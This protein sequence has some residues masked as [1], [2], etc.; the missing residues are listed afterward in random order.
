MEFL[1]LFGKASEKKLEIQ[2]Q[3]VASKA[4][5]SAVNDFTSSYASTIPKLYEV[6]SIINNCEDG[7]S[8]FILEQK[9]DGSNNAY[10]LDYELAKLNDPSSYAKKDES[11]ELF[12]EVLKHYNL[13]STHST[14]HTV[15]RDS[16]V[17]RTC[18]FCS[19]SKSEGASFKKKAHTVPRALGNKYHKSWN[20]CDECNGFF[21][22]N[23]EPDLL[24]FL[25]V[26]RS[27]TGIKGRGKANGYSSTEYEK[28][29]IWHDG[30]N[31]KFAS[32]EVKENEDGSLSI[33]LGKGGSFVP[34]NVYRAITKIALGVIPESEL[35]FLQKTIEWVRH[36][37]SDKEVELPPVASAIVPFNNISSA[38]LMLYVRKANCE[39][40]PY[41]IAE[42]QLGVYLYVFT[43]PFT[44][45][46]EQVP[47][48]F[49]DTYKFQSVFKHYFRKEIIWN[50]QNLS[51]ISKVDN[52]TILTFKKAEDNS[53]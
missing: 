41:I 4:L 34:A 9:P 45:Y 17:T 23:I 3:Q 32:K 11:D 6:N 7:E 48:S 14:Q 35:K 44:E 49:F 43:L 2:G 13:F 8:F 16:E 10:E 46:K 38:N 50:Q 53:N 47:P 39:E 1:C 29:R 36:G 21:G 20:E 24:N 18:R 19:R 33:E 40:C 22:A 15:I 28:G 12:G 27:V 25:A 30:K 42:F 31:P 26:Q 5:K 52:P 51:G 37:S